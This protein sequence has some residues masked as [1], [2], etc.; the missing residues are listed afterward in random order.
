METDTK[1]A[2]IKHEYLVKVVYGVCT[3]HEAAT[4]LVQKSIDNLRKAVAQRIQPVQPVQEDIFE[5]QFLG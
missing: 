4:K 2:H 1:T 3:D 5:V